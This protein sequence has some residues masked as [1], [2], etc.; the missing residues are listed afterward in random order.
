MASVLLACVEESF[1]TSTAAAHTACF[2]QELLDTLLLPLLPTAR[3]EN[4][5]SY[6]LCQSVLSSSSVLLQGHITQ[7]TNSVL[8]GTLTESSSRYAEMD[9]EEEEEEDGKA[10][11]NGFLTFSSSS[12]ELAEH[13]YS[14]VYELHKIAPA[15]LL[16]ILPN[17]CI[18]L[19]VNI[20][21]T[22][23]I[24]LLRIHLS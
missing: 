6:A 19:Q 24:I 15:L 9:S 23:Q 10:K 11:K 14:L 12:S 2:D 16:R 21:Y 3:Q 7:F 8:V 20:V 17:V 22:S 13:I 4:P 18:Q 5:A 1:D